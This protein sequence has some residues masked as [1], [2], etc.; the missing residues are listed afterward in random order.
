MAWGFRDMRLRVSFKPQ[1]SDD[2]YTVLILGVRAP[3]TKLIAIT[4]SKVRRSGPKHGLTG[5]FYR[6]PQANYV[7]PGKNYC[8][9]IEIPI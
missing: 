1:N 5:G 7:S 6:A 4:L 9:L 2:N 8:I 3:K